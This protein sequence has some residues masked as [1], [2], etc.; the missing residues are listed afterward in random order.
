MEG[1][2]QANLTTREAG[3]GSFQDRGGGR[4]PSPNM[5][6]R[7]NSTSFCNLGSSFLILPKSF[8]CDQ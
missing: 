8:P 4:E 6:P 7:M 5:L 3:P 2:P 1:L